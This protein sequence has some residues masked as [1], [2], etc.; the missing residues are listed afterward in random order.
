MEISPVW[1]TGTRGQVKREGCKIGI[2]Y[3]VELTRIRATD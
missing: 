1:D 2:P 3:R